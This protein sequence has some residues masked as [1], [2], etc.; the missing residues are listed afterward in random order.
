MQ[1][2]ESEKWFSIY[3]VER[4]AFIRKVNKKDVEAEESEVGSDVSPKN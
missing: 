1:R 4:D 3:S 2:D